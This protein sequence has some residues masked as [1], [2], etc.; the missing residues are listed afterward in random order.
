M[1][2]HVHVHV[3]APLR[4]SERGGRGLREGGAG[5]WES[6]PRWTQGY[7]LYRPPAIGQCLEPCAPGA[8]CAWAVQ[9]KGRSTEGSLNRRAVQP[10]GRSTD[11][12]RSKPCRSLASLPGETDSSSEIIDASW[13][14]S[15]LLERRL[16]LR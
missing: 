15:R 5:G 16:L 13:G 10:K 7:R 6:C 4:T 8:V 12:A 11:S 9:P 14:E 3:H 1:A 2:V